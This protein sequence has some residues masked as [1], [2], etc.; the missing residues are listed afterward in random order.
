MY[1]STI[2]SSVVLLDGLNKSEE[3]LLSH[4][5]ATGTIA[6][7]HTGKYYEVNNNNTTTQKP[8]KERASPK[9]P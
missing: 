2:N 7:T 4:N 8:S 3:L 1:S 5:M 6:K 9:L